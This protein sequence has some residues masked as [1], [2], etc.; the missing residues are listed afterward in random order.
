MN[1]IGTHQHFTGLSQP[2]GSTMGRT[3]GLREGFCPLVADRRRPM[4]LPGV[5][6]APRLVSN[7]AVS[8]FGVRAYTGA[9]VIDPETHLVLGTVCGIDPEPRP[10]DAH[11]MLATSK[12]LACELHSLLRHRTT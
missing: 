10:G 11:R 8:A 3:M 6:A 5:C 4:A 12:D 1:L 9:P 7:I 2:A